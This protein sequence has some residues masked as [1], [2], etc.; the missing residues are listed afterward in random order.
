[1]DQP[2]LTN[3]IV[4]YNQVISEK[5]GEQKFAK[6]LYDYRKALEALQDD[7]ASQ[8]VIKAALDL[9]TGNETQPVTSV[10]DQHFTLVKYFQAKG[11]KIASGYI[12]DPAMI[13]M[14]E[15]EWDSEGFYLEEQVQ[16]PK[17]AEPVKNSDRVEE[18]RTEMLRQIKEQQEKNEK[19]RN[20][21]YERG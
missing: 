12:K 14:I 2:N 5:E 9:V 11:R 17:A 8:H 19:D 13:E 18:K 16:Q 4:K 10:E 1:M 3:L 15:R 6:L 21:D 7:A 20:K